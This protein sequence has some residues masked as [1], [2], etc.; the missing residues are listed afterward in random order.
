MTGDV[1]MMGNQPRPA[2]ILQSPV[3]HSHY[4]PQ[5]KLS[6]WESRQRYPKP[7]SPASVN[8][9]VSAQIRCSGV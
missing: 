4:Q 3:A 6:Y 9:A 5:R 1:N 7:K 2:V 8:S